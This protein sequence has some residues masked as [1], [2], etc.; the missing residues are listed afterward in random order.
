MSRIVQRIRAKQLVAEPK[1]RS[2]FAL[3]ELKGML[4]LTRSPHNLQQP[5]AL[6]TRY[7]YIHTGWYLQEH[8][9]TLL[10]RK[11]GYYRERRTHLRELGVARTVLTFLTLCVQKQPQHYTLVADYIIDRSQ[12]YGQRV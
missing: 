10:K 7:P 3:W 11:S 1:Q 9:I 6:H 5:P 12:N 8:A 2:C 4:V